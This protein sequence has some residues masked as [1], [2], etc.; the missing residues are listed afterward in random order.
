MSRSDRGPSIAA[1]VLVV[2]VGLSVRFPITS[3]S[4]LLL[5]IGDEFDMPA[6]GPTV[7]SAI[8]VLMFG[9]V[10]PLA[11]LLVSRF[12][13]E[14]AI[15]FLM[16]ALS[17]A[18]LLR[19]VSAPMLYIGTV[20]V[21]ATIAVLGILAPHIIRRSLSRRGGFWT[22]IYTTSFGISAAAGAAFTVPILHLLDD[23]V[24]ATLSMWGV[25][26][27]IATGLVIG[28]TRSGSARLT[29]AER[30]QVSKTTPALSVLG[31]PG[32]WA[33]T[34]FFTC[35]AL[36]YFSLTAWLPT[37]AASRGMSATEA[38]LTLAWMSVAGL[39]ASLL[40]PTLASRPKLRTPIIVGVALAAVT[41]LLVFALG[42]TSWALITVAILGAAQS[43]AFGL[44]IALIVYVA[45]SAAQTSA[46]SALSQGVGYS[47]AALG[48]LGLGLL[49]QAGVSW[50]VN[51]MLLAAVA[52]FELFFGV[53]ASR[54]ARQADLRRSSV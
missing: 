43:A 15:V 19:P 52:V 6:Y 50:N 48:P 20:V 27:L 32:I 9:L 24:A 2:A 28:F 34:G 23:S 18:T 26:L 4:P 39:P 53:S 30:Q 21:G 37:I 40:A 31:T 16:A 33:I 49:V 7:I 51:L 5:G 36:I 14:R 35:Q 46:F 11:P 8:P 17:L 22:G 13:L 47:I 45:P 25:P 10:S 3:V 42:P 29:R 44:S 38:G 41:A 12:G 1:A 54:A